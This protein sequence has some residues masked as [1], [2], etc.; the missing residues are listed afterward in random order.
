MARARRP[1]PPIARRGRDVARR[2]RDRVVDRT[3]RLGPRSRDRSCAR[4]PRRGVRSSR[5]IADRR[6]APACE[7]RVGASCGEDRDAVRARRHRPTWRALADLLALESSSRSAWCGGLELGNRDSNPNFDV[8]SVACCRYTIP[9][10]T[11]QDQCLKRVY[12]FPSG[13]LANICSVPEPAAD[14]AP[15]SVDPSLGRAAGRNAE[16][17]RE[18]YSVC[19]IDTG[20]DSGALRIRHQAARD[21]APAQPGTDDSELPHRPSPTRNRRSPIAG[22]GGVRGLQDQDTRGSGTAARRRR[23][24]RGHRSCARDFQTFRQ[25]PRAPPGR[26]DR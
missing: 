19:E 18:R 2:G 9:Q 17:T 26:S 20:C 16:S 25:L 22:T 15:E 3:T 1:Q 4:A 13:P 7:P 8:Q 24:A 21:R 12:V 11:E 5:A 10:C 23:L 6:A 14:P